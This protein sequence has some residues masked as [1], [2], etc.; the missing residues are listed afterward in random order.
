MCSLFFSWW[1]KQRLFWLYFCK[2]P[3]SK[4]KVLKLDTESKEIGFTLSC[5][6]VW[7]DQTNSSTCINVFHFHFL[8]EVQQI[9]VESSSFGCAICNTR[10]FMSLPLNV[11]ILS[12]RSDEKVTFY[13]LD[14]PHLFYLFCWIV[15]MA[16][17]GEGEGEFLTKSWA[18][19]KLLLLVPWSY[20]KMVKQLERF[21]NFSLQMFQWEI[22]KS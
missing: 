11:H 17:R 10:I 4:W 20:I 18:V 15:N 8:R 19:L 14:L 7:T 6:Y 16:P 3:A 22:V 12:V 2:E 13:H 1:D 9:Y 5:I 21:T